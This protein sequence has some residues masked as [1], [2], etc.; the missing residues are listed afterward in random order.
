MNNNYLNQF[1]EQKMNQPIPYRKGE[2]WGYSNIW[3]D[4]IIEPEYEEVSFFRQV[5]FLDLESLRAWVKKGNYF[6]VIDADNNLLTGGYKQIKFLSFF[7]FPFSFFEI[8]SSKEKKGAFFKNNTIAEPIYDVIE[9]EDV[10]IKVTLNNKCGLI[11]SEGKIII[12]VKYDDIKPIETDNSSGIVQEWEAVLN[13]RIDNYSYIS[14]IEKK[15][16]DNLVDDDFIDSICISITSEENIIKRIYN[17]T[18]EGAVVLNSKKRI[19]PNFDM[20]KIGCVIGYGDEEKV[21]D[22]H[23]MNKKILFIVSNEGRFGIID[24]D[25]KLILPIEMD[26]IES[27]DG[28]LFNIEKHGE[29]GIYNYINKTSFLTNANTVAL[30]EAI[31]LNK[32]AEYKIYKITNSEEKKDYIGENGIKYFED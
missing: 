15:F 26:A 28:V 20:L 30:E 3:G 5:D 2:V 1:F 8:T 6:Y 16:M 24:E 7:G 10:G 25:S 27:F 29:K 18:K 19:E 14:D 9:K 32:E 23:K 22:Y 11:D 31:S 21:I 13:N 17:K 4:I 12:P